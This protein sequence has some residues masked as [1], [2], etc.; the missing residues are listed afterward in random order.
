[1]I[2]NIRQP[3]IS[4]VNTIFDIDLKSFEVPWDASIWRVVCD[5]PQF[6]KLV[7][8]LFGVAVGFIIWKQT[9]S[10]DI[11][12]FA[13]KPNYRGRGI[14]TSLIK[15]VRNYAIKNKSTL[16]ILPVPEILCYTTDTGRWLNKQGFKASGIIKGGDDVEDSIRFE[17]KC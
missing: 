2:H 5:D 6:N 13:V 16:V 1:M 11:W 7:A 4:D 3:E 12:R 17:L 9:D 8:T 14:G 15:A 10:T